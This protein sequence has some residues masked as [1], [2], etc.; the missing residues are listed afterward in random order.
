MPHSHLRHTRRSIRWAGALT[1]LVA[2]PA[3]LA[4]APVSAPAS[5]ADD[6]RDYRT[7]HRAAA[8]PRP[9][10]WTRDF[11][12]PSVVFDGTRWFG[13]ATGFRGRGSAA[14][15]D[16]AAWNP[17]GDL[18]NAKPASGDPTSSRAPPDGW[19]TTRCPRA[20]CRTSRTGASASQRHRR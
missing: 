20:A 9:L 18:L 17:T 12:D 13:A 4:F 11:G 6:G 8:A 10:I 3:L 1:A 5:R 15:F 2:L 19:L 16:Y 14:D 7:A